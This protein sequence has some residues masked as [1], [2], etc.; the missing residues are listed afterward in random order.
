MTGKNIGDL[1]NAKNVTW[2]WF[3]GGFAPT[4][5]R[6]AAGYAVCGATH[7]NVGGAAVGRLL[8]APRPVRVLQVDGE[9]APPAADVRGRDR[10][11]RPGQPP[12]RPVGLRH[13]AHGGQHAGRQLPEGG[14]V[15]GRPPGLLRPAGR[16]EL[17]RQRGSTRSRSRS[18]G[19]PPRSSSP[20][21][22]PTAG[23][24]TPTPPRGQRLAR[25]HRSTSRRCAA[26]AGPAGRDQRPLRLRPPAAAAG[27][28][29]VHQGE[30]RRATT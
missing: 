2:G 9:P 28:L 20:T 6:H 26:T 4:T 14:R 21:T 3:Q 23:T 15:P 22:T 27:D 1:L 7:A 18:T 24:T 17:P 30:L 10:P 19:S 29:A 16:A 11:Q 25:R 13:R 5:R 12:V 8:A